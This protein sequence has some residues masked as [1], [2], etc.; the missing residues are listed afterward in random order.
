[1]NM[2]S[3]RWR[4]FVNVREG[5]ELTLM[6]RSALSC[7]SRSCVCRDE[8]RGEG[9]GEGLW[10]QENQGIKGNR[11]KTSKRKAAVQR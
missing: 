4:L 3:A 1:M 2:H 6:D 10:L 8:G 11:H 9:G 5:T 7:S